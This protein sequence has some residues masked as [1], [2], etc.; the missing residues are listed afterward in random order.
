MKVER[1]YASGDRKR[2]T[3][4]M[5]GH[6]LYITSFLIPIEDSAKTDVKIIDS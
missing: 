5:R 2:A 3:L 6:I 4:V 1:Y